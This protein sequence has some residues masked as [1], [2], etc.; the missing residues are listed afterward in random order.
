MATRNPRRPAGD[1]GGPMIH[2][3][4]PTERFLAKMR[5]AAE[6]IESIATRR[7]ALNT[8]S[9]AVFA[10]LEAH[11]LNK[12]AVRKALAYMRLGPEDRE[13]FDWTYAQMRL[14]LGA[15]IQPDLFVEQA[16]KD[17]D[18]EPP[19]KRGSGRPRGTKGKPQ[20]GAGE[21]PPLN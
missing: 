16:R 8:E 5:E 10:N 1:D 9:A 6:E 11:G 13:N 18:S 12:I 7:K 17:L 20:T 3:G 4:Q 14:A 19:A 2:D 21:M 15:P